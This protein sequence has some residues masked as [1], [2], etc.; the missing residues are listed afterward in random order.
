[1]STLEESL[2]EELLTTNNEYRRLFDEHQDQEG[3]LEVLSQKASFSQEDEVEEKQIKLS[4]LHLKDQMEA[5][6]QAS[7][8][9]LVRS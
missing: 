3:R 2:K 7:Q 6:Y 1:M 5:I 9:S 4:K 8:E